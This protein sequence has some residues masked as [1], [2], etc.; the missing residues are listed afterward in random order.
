MRNYGSFTRAQLTAQL[1]PA[2]CVVG[3]IAV[4]TDEGSG[5][6]VVVNS[7]TAW[8]PY[9]QNLGV[10]TVATL[11]AASTAYKGSRA[12]VSD[13]NATCTAGIGAVVA[14]GGANIVPVYCEGT[15]WRIG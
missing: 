8:N 12:T 11:P 6:L 10:L 9:P 3:A 14:G 2:A 5:G 13:A 4:V 15:A 1:V 7:G